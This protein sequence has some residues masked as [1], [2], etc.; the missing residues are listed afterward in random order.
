MIKGMDLSKWNGKGN[1]DVAISKGIE[2][3]II[4][5]GSI[6]SVTGECYL[7]YLLQ[8][9]L[10]EIQ[11]TKLPF[12][13]YF[14]TRP[15]FSAKVQADYIIANLANLPKANLEF[16]IDVEVAGSSVQ[17]TTN[18]VKDIYNYITLAG[19]KAMIYTRQSFWDSAVFADPLWS[20]IKA[21][22][23]RYNE[24]LTGPWS[25]NKYVPRDWSTWGYWQYTSTASA[26]DYG[27]PGGPTY[28][29]GIDLDW[30]NGTIEQFKAEYNIVPEI[31][32][33]EEII[34]LKE[35]IAL[36]ENKIPL[37]ETRITNL[38]GRTGN[39]ENRINNISNLI[40]KIKLALTQQ[41][42]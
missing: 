21:W 42:I 39:A 2:F 28:A 4:R 18:F 19:Y 20:T 7:D 10:A 41:P 34:K 30:Y 38:E 13:Y 11:R 3:A 31:S 40:T 35:R 32:L 29:V 16:A 25:D 37:L 5:L 24:L 36:L 26:I 9:H 17:A 27:F 1:F 8:D 33:E 15:L 23:A 22:M 6:D 12:G 14:Y